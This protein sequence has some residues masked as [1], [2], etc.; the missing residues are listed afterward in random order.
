MT[1]IQ[2]CRQLIANGHRREALEVLRTH[3]ETPDVLFLL[4]LCHNTDQ[5]LHWHRA[6]EALGP[7]PSK[8][9]LLA[10]GQAITQTRKNL[11]FTQQCIYLHQ[12]I[13]V[14]KALGQHIQ[15]IHWTSILANRLLRLGNT[16]QAL[17]WLQQAVQLSIQHQHHLAT[18]AQGLILSGIWFS[19]GEI[20]RVSALSLSIEHAATQ[21]HNWLAFATARNTRAS[22][23]LIR[24]Q[25]REAVS[26]LLEGGDQLS[27]KGALAALNIL[28]ARLGELHLLLG[29]Q[30]ITELI[31]ANQNGSAS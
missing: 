25:Q 1:T 15:Q 29:Q 2:D 16:D 11:N 12:A 24:G 8:D 23:L 19:R 30:R 27:S 5:H 13:D 26:A 22:C 7:T 18:I 3:P 31:Q 17:P 9:L 28:K 21:R 4:A 6:I 20:D 10:L 14:S